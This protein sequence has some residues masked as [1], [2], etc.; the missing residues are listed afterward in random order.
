MP[1]T[2]GVGHGLFGERPHARQPFL[3]QHQLIECAPDH[4][5]SPGQRD[6]SQLRS[7]YISV[8]EHE[9]YSVYISRCP[10]A[11]VVAH[12]MSDRWTLN[13]CHRKWLQRE[14]CDLHHIPCTCGA[15]C[16]AVQSCRQ[17]CA[18][19]PFFNSPAKWASKDTKALTPAIS[20]YDGSSTC[21]LGCAE[22][23]EWEGVFAGRPDGFGVA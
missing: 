21:F 17:S 16:Q 13:H 3:M 11:S 20:R 14:G 19:W 22:I 12:P 7:A 1:A 18:V 8:Q 9:A 4:K 23:V 10:P 5:L 2:G 6:L 15:L